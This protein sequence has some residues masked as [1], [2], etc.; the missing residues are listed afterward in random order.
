VQVRCEWGIS[1]SQ[2]SLI[3]SIVF[4]GTMAG[5]YSW[6]ILGDVRGRRVGFFGTAAFT[7]VF[8]ALS[9]ASPNYL[10]RMRIGVCG[11]DADHHFM[12]CVSVVVRNTPS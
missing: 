5:A 7:F 8:G 2:E 12:K 4:C 3:T 1:P 11:F 6:G 10:V 9:A